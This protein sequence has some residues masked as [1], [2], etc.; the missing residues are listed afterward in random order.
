MR[1]D[2]LEGTTEVR[3]TAI[4]VTLV[5]SAATALTGCGSSDQSTSSAPPGGT[6]IPTTTTPAPSP[7]IVI[8]NFSYAVRGPL[9]P[10]QHV[11]VI[12]DDQANHS[13]AT[14]TSGAIDLR[15][16][17]GGGMETFTAPLTP[18]VYAIHCKYHAN[19][20]GSLIV[21]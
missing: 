4:L 17:G 13:I 21:Q 12:N 16:S 20:H 18:G 7:D 1:S 2:R 11:L 5:V 10:G 19:M 14:D 8:S 9:R 15:V 3:L 6:T